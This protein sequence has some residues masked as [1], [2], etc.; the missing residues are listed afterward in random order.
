M[1]VQIMWS[2]GVESTSLLKWFLENTNDHIFAH[3]VE[4]Q[5]WEGRL[6]YEQRAMDTLEPRLQ[7]IRPFRVI[8]SSCSIGNGRVCP[9]DMHIIF[10][11]GLWTHRHYNMDVSYRAHC[12][13]DAER[14]RGH[15]HQV[16][17][18]DKFL[19]EGEVNP[20]QYHENYK[21]RKRQ[22]WEYLGDLAPLTWSCRVPKDCKVCGTCHSCLLR[23]NF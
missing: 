23:E 5:N 16:G 1:R 6:N 17:W 22:H 20:F 12:L 19:Y 14:L 18:L 10:P 8:R 21:W 15:E 11:Y 13:E 9:E 4:L 7:A 3:N 2:G